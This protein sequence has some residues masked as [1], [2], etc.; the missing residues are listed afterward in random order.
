MAAAT[1]TWH[2]L[3]HQLCIAPTK[4]LLRSSISSS[5]TARSFHMAAQSHAPR[6][7]QQQAPASAMASLTRFNSSCPK[8]VAHECRGGRRKNCSPKLLTSLLGGFELLL[9]LGRIMQNVQGLSLQ[10]C[11]RIADTPPVPAHQL[12][13]PS[14]KP[15]PAKSPDILEKHQSYNDQRPGGWGAGLNGHNPTL[16]E[17]EEA[18]ALELPKHE[19]RVT[20][21]GSSPFFRRGCSAGKFT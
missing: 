13:H 5:K 1:F 12:Q 20:P 6:S 14:R 3:W 18:L 15:E 17:L 9:H 11:Q 2:Q 4:W 16:E 8:H 10:V 21:Q 7:L 19:F